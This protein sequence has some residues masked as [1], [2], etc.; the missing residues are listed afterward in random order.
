MI[1]LGI[2]G[3]GNLGR[4]VEAAVKHNPDTELVAV[5]TRRDPSSVK[6]NS[7]AKVYSSSE[8]EAQEER[9]QDLLDY[10]NYTKS[11]KYIENTARSK[12]GLVYDDEMIFREKE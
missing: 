4:G 1:R 10:E 3:Y 12:L 2:L 6:I 11:D 7:N 9:K 5:F 8:L